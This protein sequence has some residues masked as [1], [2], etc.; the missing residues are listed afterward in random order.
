VAA[1]WP[2]GF[3]QSKPVATAHAALITFAISGHAICAEASLH[4]ASKA[5]N[6]QGSLAVCRRRDCRGHDLVLHIGI[7]VAIADRDGTYRGLLGCPVADEGSEARDQFGATGHV[8]N[9]RTSAPV[10]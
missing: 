8:T 1:T 2:A 6:Q 10:T 3:P 7:S 9:S 5:E 4:Q